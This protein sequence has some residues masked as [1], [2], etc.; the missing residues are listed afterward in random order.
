MALISDLTGF[1]RGDF[2][3]IFNTKEANYQIGK[4]LH[5]WLKN[6]YADGLKLCTSMGMGLSFW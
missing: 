2:K 6:S 3:M 5:K 1:K 4:S